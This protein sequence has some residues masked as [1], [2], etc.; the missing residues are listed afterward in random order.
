MLGCVSG[1]DWIQGIHQ[2]A[3]KR[4]TR[5]MNQNGNG[6]GAGAVQVGAFGTSPPSTNRGGKSGNDLGAESAQSVTD[7]SRVNVS[8][9]P[10]V[11]ASLSGAAEKLGTSISQIALAA[12]MAGIPSLAEQVESLDRLKS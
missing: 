3:R 12:I 5:A 1:T 11:Y 8:L 2:M 4:V 7:R 10:G 6:L 9:P